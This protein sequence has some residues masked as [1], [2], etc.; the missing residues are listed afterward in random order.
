MCAECGTEVAGADSLPTVAPFQPPTVGSSPFAP[1]TVAPAVLAPGHVEAVS[2]APNG[3][4]RKKWLLPAALAVVVLGGGLLVWKLTK[5][6]DG[7]ANPGSTIPVE[8]TLV[9]ET[10][11]AATT[12]VETTAVATTVVE[13]TE[14]ETTEVETTAVETTVETTV[15]PT[16][17][18]VTE[19]PPP[20][21]KPPSVPKL[22]SFAGPGLAYPVSNPLVGGMNPDEAAPYLLFAQSVFDK[23]A[24]DDWAGVQPTFY[25]QLPDGQV[26]PYTFDLQSQ[27]PSADRLS[28]LLVNA[29]PDSTG[30]TGD[31]LTVAVVANFPGSTSILCG[32]LYSDPNNYAEVIQRGPFALMADGLPPTMPEALLND[33]TQVASLQANC[34]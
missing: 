3:G 31:D 14:V 11:G 12:V 15:P 7:N 8:T 28:L 32:H 6:D 1:P 24:A 9:S 2:G 16:N 5:S 21:W 4:A 23:M 13:T 22:A 25:F 33:P 29:A 18:P 19:P 34:K 20:A 17:P 26:V 10:T 27:W 30:L